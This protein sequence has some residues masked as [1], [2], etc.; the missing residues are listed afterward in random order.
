MY[1]KKKT[2]KFEKIIVP[3]KGSNLKFKVKGFIKD[4]G[5][6]ESFYNKI[7]PRYS[8]KLINNGDKYLIEI[9]F[10]LYGKIKK[11]KRK[12]LSD[13]DKNQYII[14]IRGEIKEIEKISDFTGD[15]EYSEFDFQIII[16][17]FIL[18]DNEQKEMEIDIV[19][20]DEKDIP[21]EEENKYG[22]YKFYLEPKVYFNE[23]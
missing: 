16:Q 21:Y 17:K 19:D 7:N 4:L 14:F 20:Q 9:I 10:E 11:L 2:R 23:V 8:T 12:I 6:N 18:F 1:D 15:L 22:V 13:E 3:L 5:G